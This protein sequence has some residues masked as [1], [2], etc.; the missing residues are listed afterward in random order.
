MGGLHECWVGRLILIYQ[1]G[2]GEYN[3]LNCT[4]AAKGIVYCDEPWQTPLNK[5][6]IQGG[7]EEQRERTQV[8][9]QARREKPKVGHKGGEGTNCEVCKIIN[10]GKSKR[11]TFYLVHKVRVG[12]NISSFTGASR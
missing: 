12:V 6:P 11:L 10:L 4:S 3:F 1:L 5:A 7:K 8:Q 2:K 9:V